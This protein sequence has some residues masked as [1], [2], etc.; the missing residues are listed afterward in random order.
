MEGPPDF[1]AGKARI[2][3]KLPIILSFPPTVA[4]IPLGLRMN[5]GTFCQETD[6]L[7]FTS[8]DI[9]ATPMLNLSWMEPLSTFLS[10]LLK[11][12]Y[13]CGS[14]YYLRSSNA[15]GSGE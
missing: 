1:L 12:A 15:S 9:L 4:L 3:V 8:A 5:S 2:E 13:R 14:V 10:F 7:K 11:P 6:F